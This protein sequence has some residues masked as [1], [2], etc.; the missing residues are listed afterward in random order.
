LLGV[1]RLEGGSC[2]G[3]ESERLTACDAHRANVVGELIRCKLGCVVAVTK[4]GLACSLQVD[5]G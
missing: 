4:R 5:G 1:S 3:E 2:C